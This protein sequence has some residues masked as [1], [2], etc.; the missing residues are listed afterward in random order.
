MSKAKF[1]YDNFTDEDK[2]NP[3]VF[4]AHAKKFTKE[5]TLELFWGE[6]AFL[7]VGDEP[8]LKREPTIADVIGGQYVKY[9]PV[10]PDR[11]DGIPGYMLIDKPIKGSFPVWAIDIQKL[12]EEG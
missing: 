10:L 5:E 11:L 6:N 8:Y 7:Y 1:E 3:E 2:V 12:R 4:A 9:Y